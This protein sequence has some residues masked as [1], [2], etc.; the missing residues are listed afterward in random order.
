MWKIRFTALILLILG[1]LV[2]Y[3]VFVSEKSDG[4]FAFKLG[5]DLSG[6]THLAYKADVSEIEAAEVK[7]AMESLRDVIE[8]R[9]NLFGVTEPIVQVE[10]TAGIISESKEERLI[11]ELPGVTNIDEAVAMIGATPVLEFRLER[12]DGPAKDKILNELEKFQETLKSGAEISQENIP[13]VDELFLSTGLTGRFLEKATLAF[14]STTGAPRI[15]LDFDDEGSTLFATI[16]KNNVGKI[17]AIYLDGVP[18]SQ[19]TIQQ[20]IIGGRA[21]ITGV[22]TPQEA[23]ILVGRLNSGA[24]PIPVELLGSQ[25]IG[26]SLGADARS[27]GV[28][29]GILGLLIIA[30]FMVLW[31]RLPGL[32]S[33]VALG[34]YT[35]LMLAIFKLIPVTLTAAGVAGFIL[36]IGMAVDANILIFERMKEELRTGKGLESA[37]KEGFA[38]AWLSIRDSNISSMLTAVILFWFG[39]SIIE[40]FALVFGLG[41]LVSMFT[42][43]SVSRTLLFAVSFESV[44]E[45]ISKFLFGTGIK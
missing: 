21:E 20:E 12:P 28:K 33:V 13:N 41:V 24:L 34:I 38:R 3:F 40:G 42:A 36:S 15:L 9:V 17:L 19:P 2:G 44:P 18:I 45:G 25:T 29:A 5:L 22:F 6:G 30:I 35:A 43:V 10:R 37:V 7:D 16:T 23:K 11:V 32:V 27:Q 31:Y 8:R 26:S 14:D 4:R 39:S 1:S